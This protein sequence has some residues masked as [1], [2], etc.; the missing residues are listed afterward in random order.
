MSEAVVDDIVAM[1]PPLCNQS[2]RSLLSRVTSTRPTSTVSCRRSA[3]RRSRCGQFGRGSPMAGT[4]R[5][6]GR[7]ARIIE[8]CGARGF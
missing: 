7:G 3:R 4:I 5:G 6:R 1:L 8:R 2:R